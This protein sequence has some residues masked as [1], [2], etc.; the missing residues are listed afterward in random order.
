[1]EREKVDWVA[2]SQR[3]LQCG[4]MFSFNVLKLSAT[5]STRTFDHPFSVLPG[6]EDER[7][8]DGAETEQKPEMEAEEKMCLCCGEETDGD[9]KE[10]AKTTCS[11]RR[12]SSASSEDSVISPNKVRCRLWVCTVTALRIHCF[13]TRALGDN[14]RG[15][16]GNR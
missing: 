16:N 1:M 13:S 8:E 12:E 2:L 11:C 14:G 6:E 7:T 15:N 9:E 3:C 10:K 5:Q 4:L